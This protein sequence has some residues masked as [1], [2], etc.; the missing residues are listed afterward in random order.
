MQYKVICWGFF[1][2]KW[3]ASFLLSSLEAI[4]KYTQR[5]SNH[6]FYCWQNCIHGDGLDLQR[7]MLGAM[8][9]RIELMEQTLNQPTS[10]SIC[11]PPCTCWTQGAR[12][13]KV[14]QPCLY[15][16]ALGSDPCLLITWKQEWGE[17]HL[18]SRSAKKMVNQGLSLLSSGLVS[19]SP[20]R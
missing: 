1:L 9:A 13:E 16:A 19:V 10:R 3:I 14:L 6:R 15:K 20:I 11:G 4:E 18:S 12:T 8:F 17:H 2:C 5:S 7:Q